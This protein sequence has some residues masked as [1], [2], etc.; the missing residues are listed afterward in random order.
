MKGEMHGEWGRLAPPLSLTGTV[1]RFPFF[2]P[3]LLVEQVQNLAS[4]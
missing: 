4:A 3:S 1:G 2:H